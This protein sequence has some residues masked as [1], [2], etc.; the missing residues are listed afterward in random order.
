MPDGKGFKQKIGP[1]NLSVELRAEQRRKINRG[2][3]YQNEE[4]NFLPPALTFNSLIL[5]EELYA[6]APRLM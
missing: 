4:D 3:S 1:I 5:S 2:D 6:T